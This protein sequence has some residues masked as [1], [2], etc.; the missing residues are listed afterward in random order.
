MKVIGFL[1]LMTIMLACGKAPEM[2]DYSR[3]GKSFETLSGKSNEEIFRLKYNHQI[4][5]NCEM[6]VNQGQKIDL[7]FDPAD[8]LSWNVPSELSVMKILNYKAGKKYYVV[9]IKLGEPIKILERVDYTTHDLKEYFM[10]HSPVVKILY[11]RAER[12]ALSDGSIHQAETFSEVFLYENIHSHLF[13]KTSRTDEDKFVTEELR[14]R[15][16]TKVH[17]QYKHQWQLIK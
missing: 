6:R 3:P 17:P 5:L 12:K 1:L 10:E 11:K 15:L 9:V 13:T 14:C 16:A 7:N 2:K 4:N 8:T